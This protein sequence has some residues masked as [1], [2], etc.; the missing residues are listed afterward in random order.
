MIKLDANETAFLKKELEHIKTET[1]DVK[2]EE[3]KARTLIPVNS[4][5]GDHSEYITYRSYNM[6]GMAKIVES[7]AKD[8][9]R[10]DVSVVEK[11]VKVY[12]LG[13]SYGYSLQE[14]RQSNKTG[15]NL[16]QKKSNAA[17]RAM[18]QAE[19]AF[20][21]FG[22]AVLG[23][24]GLLN[25]P[26]V[27]SIAPAA[28]GAWSTKDGDQII[29]DIAALVDGMCTATKGLEVP[30]TMLL[31]KSLLTIMR[32]KR[33]PDGTMTI[34][35][36]AMEAFPEIKN[37]DWLSDLDTAGAGST[38]RIV[39]YRRNRDALELEIPVDFEQFEPQQ[40]G[41]EFVVYCHERIAGTIVYYPLSLAY[42]DGL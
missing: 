30:D 28:A 33:M 41:L 31:P 4:S 10:V 6:F 40:E 24:F 25:H 15:K 18:M 11:S 16:D 36:Y 26:N 7:Y 19:N 38:K 22:N 34:M 27:P 42:M 29:A 5:A 3:L 8:F 35:K 39:L 14:V 21:L 13:D 23:V 17:K 9:P 20:A 32:T 1:Y 37:W 12:P 2:F